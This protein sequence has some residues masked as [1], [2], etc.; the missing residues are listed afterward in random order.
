[1]GQAEL[2]HHIL[3]ARRHVELGERHIARQREIIERLKQQGHDT[4][5]AERLLNTFEALQ[6]L[7]RMNLQRHL[8]LLGVH[9]PEAGAH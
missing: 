4:S 7:H 2:E 3:V 6:A 8:E 5:S 1:M 9:D